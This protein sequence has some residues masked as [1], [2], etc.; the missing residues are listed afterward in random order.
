[1][2]DRCSDPENKDYRNYGARGI[3]VCERWLEYP[4]FVEDVLREIGPRPPGHSFDRRNNDGNYEPGNVRWATRSEQNINTRRRT[5]GAMGVSRLPSGRWQARISLG[6]FDTVT[7]A[8]SA[9][10]RARLL[11]EG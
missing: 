1:M 3:G 9:Y 11:L 2:I 8:S 5:S 7:E 10:E 4:L 6:V